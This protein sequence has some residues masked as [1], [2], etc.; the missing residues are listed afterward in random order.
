MLPIIYSDD[1]LLHET[2][3]YHP[4][5][6]E[7]LRAIVQALKA[8]PWTGQLEWRSPTPTDQ[9]DLMTD[10]R[11]VH[12]PRYVEAVQHLANRGG[13]HIDPDTPISSHSYQVALLAVS[14]WLDGVDYVQATGRPI[15]VL[16]RP[17]GH[18]ALSRDGMGFCIFSHAAIAAY[19][20]L[21]QPGIERVAI[22]DWDVH[23]GNGT[24]A[25]VESHPQIAYC[26]I[27]QAP[28]YPGTGTADEQGAYH[29]V[30]NLPVAA[31]STREE[32]EP[33]FRDQVIPFLFQ[34]QPNLLIVSAGYD[35]NQDDPL[36]GVDLQPEDFS[37]FTEYCLQ[38]THRIVFGLEGGYDL[39][40]LAQSVLATLEPCL[41]GDSV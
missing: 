37:L 5:C 12:D 25:I 32:Y 30:L 28:F 40:S 2:G 21:E 20:A 11:R 39:P 23:H 33:L 19:Y 8:A 27:H 16:A 26:S 7:R 14:A 4:E 13:G 3:S 31:G 15:F 10:L 41:R 29:N 36:A 1:F 35:A 38:L 6:P 24:Q 17:P 22:L 34:W 18:H 9:R